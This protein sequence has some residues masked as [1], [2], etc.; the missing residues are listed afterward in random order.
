MRSRPHLG[1]IIKGLKR[2]GIEFRSEEID[3]LIDRPVIH[4]LF[5]LLKALKHPC[6]RIAWLAIL[7]A[8]WCGLSP[9]RYS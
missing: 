7:R 9:F 2:E 1:E 5:S 4:D 6:D 3:P 8:P